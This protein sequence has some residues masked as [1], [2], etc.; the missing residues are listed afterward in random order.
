MIWYINNCFFLFFEKSEEF[1][2]NLTITIYEENIIMTN[3]NKTADCIAVP[4]KVSDAEKLIVNGKDITKDKTA[5]I[6]CSDPN[7]LGRSVKLI[8]PEYAQL[9]DEEAGKMV[10]D[11]EINPGSM[12]G[13][14][15]DVERA[16]KFF[17]VIFSLKQ[18]EKENH[19]EP[20]TVLV[21]IIME[22]NFYKLSFEEYIV[23]TSDYVAALY[24]KERKKY[25]SNYK[26]GVRVHAIWIALCDE[27]KGR[28]ITG[29]F[30]LNDT[31]GNDYNEYL[32]SEFSYTLCFVDFDYENIDKR[33]DPAAS[34]YSAVFTNRS[35][36][37]DKIRLLEKE[38]NFMFTQD[39]HKEIEI[40]GLEF[41]Y[42]QMYLEEIEKLKKENQSKDEKIKALLVK[43]KKIKADNIATLKGMMRELNLDFDRAFAIARYDVSLKEEYRKL[44]EEKN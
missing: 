2:R 23:R 22:P 27:F 33:I 30:N 25:G 42:N 40:N 16:V 31:Q 8:F 20:E 43:D 39:A 12:T 35:D 11:L 28:T 26:K 34:F 36:K 10:Y 18:P 4:D 32:I 19:D 41:G 15:D 6:I 3:F 37:S 13:T 38:Q 5:K 17:D 29:K 7:F 1:P 24:S 21:R 14:Y 44:I 9:S